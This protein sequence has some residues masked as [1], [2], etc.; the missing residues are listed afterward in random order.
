MDELLKDDRFKHIST[1]SRFKIMPK[2]QRKFKVDNRFKVIELQ[3][4]QFQH[5]VLK[6]HLNLSVCSM[7]KNLN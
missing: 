5:N 1:D 2:N 4:N 3:T 6:L 7:I